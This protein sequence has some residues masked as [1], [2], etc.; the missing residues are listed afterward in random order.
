MKANTNKSLFCE[1]HNGFE[2]RTEDCYDLRDTIE[3]LIRESRLAKYVGSQRSARR[4]R[5]SDHRDDE[6]RNP[7]SQRTSEPE[8]NKDHDEEELVT[9]AVNVI[10]GGFVRG[11]MTKSAKKKHL[12]E[13]F[14]VSSGKIKKLMSMLPPTLEIVFSSLDLEGMIP[15]HNDPMIIFAV[16]V[17]VEVKRVF[18]DQRSLAN[19]I[20]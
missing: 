11:K 20:F 15:R 14:N 1:Y 7:R 2:H 4:R 19:I 12:Q 17:N 5:A 16:M 8:R 13:V 6:R 3:Q 18:V 10:A 9:R